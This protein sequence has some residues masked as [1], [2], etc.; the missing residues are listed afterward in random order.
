MADAAGFS[1]EV[2]ELGRV[3]YGL[4]DSD[5]V[6]MGIIGA[7]LDDI[8]SLLLDA[9]TGKKLIDDFGWRGE[10][11]LKQGKTPQ[12]VVFRGYA[13]GRNI[14]TATTYGVK[15]AKVI[16]F[17]IG[18]QSATSAIKGNIFVSIALVGVEAT[19]DTIL[20]DEFVFSKFFSQVTLAA[21]SSAVATFA[22][23]VARSLAVTAFATGTGATAFA[24]VPPLLGGLIVGATVSYVLG[25]LIDS[26][27]LESQIG[28]LMDSVLDVWWGSSKY[29]S[30]SCVA[31]GKTHSC[32][33]NID[34]EI[35]KGGL[36][37]GSTGGDPS[38]APDWIPPFV[39]G[40]EDEGYDYELDQGPVFGGSG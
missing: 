27:G 4:P 22:A 20:G 1:V 29:I 39:P 32:T 37:G 10:Y 38:D 26:S 40:P 35:K 25:K 23:N 16:A 30:G 8:I 15:N 14:F 13:G 5:K 3:I 28:R 34:G 24:V 19:I 11:Y 18:P 17:G 9:N 12:L 2:D 36:G 33:V 6:R 7:P 31:K 21:G